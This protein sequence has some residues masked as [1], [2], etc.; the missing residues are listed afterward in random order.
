MSKFYLGNPTNTLAVIK[1]IRVRISEEIRT[2]FSYRS[3]NCG[4]NSP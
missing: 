1:Q 3:G 4:K 2:E